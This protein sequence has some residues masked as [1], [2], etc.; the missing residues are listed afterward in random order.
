MTASQKQNRRLLIIFLIALLIALL[1]WVVLA[2]EAPLE[3]QNFNLNRNEGN[4][5]G[6]AHTVKVRARAFNLPSASVE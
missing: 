1:P 3:D 2:Q 5:I 4:A 6:Y